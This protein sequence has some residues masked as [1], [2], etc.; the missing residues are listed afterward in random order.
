MWT[1][2]V[3]SLQSTHKL[4]TRLSCTFFQWCCMVS[5][6]F[7]MPVVPAKA[8]KHNIVH[9]MKSRNLRLC[10]CFS[11]TTFSFCSSFSSS[12]FLFL[13]LCFIVCAITFC[14]ICCLAFVW[15]TA[16][17]I[18]SQQGLCHLHILLCGRHCHVD[19]L[20]V[21]PTEYQALYCQ[22]PLCNLDALNFLSV[23]GSVW[24]KVLPSEVQVKNC[25]SFMGSINLL[26]YCTTT[27]RL[28]NAPVLMH[29]A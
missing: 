4:W 1:A 20:A 14:F 28:H 16:F 29:V 25:S 22:A 9:F 6:I 19:V 10:L 23:T 12:S 7:L 24:C 8:T 21:A 17:K 13:F 5:V 18:I 3:K 27:T 2:L 15:A 11:S 26:L